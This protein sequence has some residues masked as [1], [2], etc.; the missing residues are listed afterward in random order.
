MKTKLFTT[1]ALALAL[2]YTLAWTAG[3]VSAEPA[4]DPDYVRL[5]GNVI[6]VQPTGVDDT[7]N[8]QCAFDMAVAYG[9]GAHVKLAGG[10]FYTGQIVVNDFQGAFTGAGMEKTM[11]F[12]LPNLNVT[13]E[14]FYY[15]PPSAENP[16]PV[17]LNFVGGDLNISDIA[18][19]VVGD[20]PTT[21][22]TVWG[23]DP[24]LK[25]LAVGIVITGTE[26]NA[27]VDRILIEGEFK[28]DGLFGYNLI[29]GVFVE[30]FI[31]EPPLPT[32]GNFSIQDS[33]FRRMA[34][35]TP[36]ANLIDTHVLISHNTYEEV[37]FATDGG[38]F[39]DSDIEFSHNNV[40]AIIGV[41]WYDFFAPMDTGSTFL[42]K[43]N[44]FRGEIG[45]ALEQT[46][47]EGNQ[48]LI[49]GNNLQQ[50]TDVGVYLGPGTTGCMVVGGGANTSVV[51][52]GTDNILTGVNNMS[53]GI[54]PDISSLM[55]KKP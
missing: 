39:I 16:W 36:L 12:N 25:E 23:I 53:L 37:V 41:D 34:S 43:N 28:E 55:R 35:G 9:A 47:G 48:C 19:Y 54:G 52:L 26:A 31:G 49:L 46:F 38:T 1:V 2:M 40:D 30:G 6:N 33:L 21:G 51:D 5:S 45:I 3:A 11:I 44:G 17:L 13:L 8:L 22:W 50:V 29:N 7:A 27:N 24:P 15:A 10:T 14:D 32:S 4:C 18:I 20:A 42:L